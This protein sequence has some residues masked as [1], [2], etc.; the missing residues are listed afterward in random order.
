MKK[1][2][3]YV[4]STSLSLHWSQSSV[5]ILTSDSLIYASV[6]D[7]GEGPEMR[8]KGPKIPSPPSP[9]G[10]P[11]PLISRS[12]YATGSLTNLK[13]WLAWGAGGRGGGGGGGIRKLQ[14]GKKAQK[15]ALQFEVCL[16]AVRRKGRRK[17][18]FNLGRLT[19]W[20]IVQIQLHPLERLPFRLCNL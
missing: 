7:R 10:W 9:L 13:H 2:A 16:A 3:L 5:F 14:L 1:F 17:A 8:L 6:A 11:P 18:G 15:R 20:V 4:Y 19:T 12:G